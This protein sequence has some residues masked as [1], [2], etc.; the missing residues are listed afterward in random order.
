[1][2]GLSAASLLQSPSPV[3]M[4]MG[5]EH[6]HVLHEEMQ[7]LRAFIEAEFERQALKLKEI[8][9]ELKHGEFHLQERSAPSKNPSAA[10]T[11]ACSLAENHAF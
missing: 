1:M 8:V 9:S 5:E 10:K 11:H 7:E 3:A 6:E 2:L 4:N